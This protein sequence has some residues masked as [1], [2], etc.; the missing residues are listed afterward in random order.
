MADEKL[1]KGE[2]VGGKQRLDF[3]LSTSTTKWK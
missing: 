1:K 3:T 2:T